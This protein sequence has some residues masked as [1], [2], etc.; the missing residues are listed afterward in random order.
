MHGLPMF[1]HVFVVVSSCLLLRHWKRERFIWQILCKGC[2]EQL[3]FVFLCFIYGKFVMQ[4]GFS[5]MILIEAFQLSN[6]LFF[7]PPFIYE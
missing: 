5:F 3:V 1:S 6:Q 7:S 2:H 4:W